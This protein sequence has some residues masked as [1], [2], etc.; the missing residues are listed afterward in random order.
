MKRRTVLTAILGL[1]VLSATGVWLRDPNC[2]P[3]QMPASC[4]VPPYQ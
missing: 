3:I 4:L 1:P 2:A